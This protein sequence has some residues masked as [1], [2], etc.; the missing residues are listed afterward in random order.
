MAFLTGLKKLWAGKKD[1]EK[2]DVKL[3]AETVEDKRK[4]E[5]EAYL[6]AKVK[7]WMDR[8]YDE[9]GAKKKSWKE[10]EK[11]IEKGRLRGTPVVCARCN[12]HGVNHASGG[13]VKNADGS[14]SHQNPN[15]KEA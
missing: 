5:F 10:I 3:E 1:K 8:G 14:Y 6:A 12:R 13:F 4:R 2:L 9:E 11:Q 15:C 7:K